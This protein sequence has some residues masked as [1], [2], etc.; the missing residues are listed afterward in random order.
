MF[1]LALLLRLARVQVRSQMQYRTSF[2]LSLAG[3][4]AFTALD[5]ATIVLLFGDISRLGGWTVNQVALLY[6][7]SSLSYAL[8]ELTLGSLD[9]LP[10]MVRDGSFDT[11]L[12]RPGPTFV[13][14]LATDF[15]LRRAGRLLQA[16]V[17]LVVVTARYPATLW[18]AERV[19]VLLSSV[20]GGAVIMG[21]LWIVA[22]SAS[23]WANGA[24]GLVSV[25][26]AGT[27]FLV[28]YPLDVYTAWLRSFVLFVVPLGFVSYLPVS[29]VLDK[30]D[31]AGLPTAVRLA[32]PLVAAVTAGAAALVWR[33]SVR[34]YRSPG[35]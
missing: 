15:L 4:F 29:W 21:S 6:A 10:T 22:A 19:L 30:P 13:H 1:A 31:A 18:T 27:S 17:V 14:L 34:H 26:S 12:L 3:N 24:D 2:A 5:F 32:T 7:V 8:C 23:F 11:L 28:Q 25:F 33:I 35:G 9:Q 16:V 20:V